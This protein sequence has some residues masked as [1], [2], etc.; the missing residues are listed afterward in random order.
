[1]IEPVE[2]VVVLDTPVAAAFDTFV[3]RINDWW[4]VENFS[5]ACGTVAMERKLNGRIIETAEDGKQHQWGHITVWDAPNR[6]EIEWYVGENTIPTKIAV[7]FTPTDNGRTGVTLVH[8]GWDVLG[9]EG[10]TK[11]ENYQMGWDAILG[12]GYAD[13]A[14][15]TCP[16]LTETASV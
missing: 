9:A 7:D 11:R 3:D 15:A 6:L 13:H 10:V 4:P 12:K 8:S 14:R 16:P 1:M 5:I 2:V